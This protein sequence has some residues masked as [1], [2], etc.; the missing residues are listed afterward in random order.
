MDAPYGQLIEVEPGVARVLAPNPSPYT[1]TGTQVHLVGRSELA[2]IDPGPADPAH[3]DALVAAIGGRPVA[4]ILVTHT[5]K[6]HSPGA[7]PLAELTGA[8]VIGCAPL[9][10]DGEQEAGFDRDYA[11]D[12]VPADGESVMVDRRTLTAIHTP[13][14]TSNHLCF[15]D[16]AAG[17]LFSGDHVMGWSTSVVIPPDGDMAAYV[18]SLIR[19]RER[20]HDRVYYPA[21]G[22]PV[23]DPQRLVR[24]MINHR[25]QRERQ[26]LR[27]LGEDGATSLPA[28][29]ARA[30]PGLDPR[31]I[32]AA[33]A[34]ALAHL[35]ALEQQG[36]VVRSGNRWQTNA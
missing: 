27:L 28:L 7:G 4:A 31:L 26:L 8:P 20:P 1:F 34:T 11:P 9:V 5:H 15:A 12:R 3:L 16:E 17:I 22:E 32:P 18:A 29:T 21:H 23:A 36:K 35:I 14:H 19:L 13:G 33:E 24:G 6:D 30:Y 25:L 10:V 2:V